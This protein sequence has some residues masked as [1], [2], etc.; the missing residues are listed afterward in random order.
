MRRIG[1]LFITSGLPEDVL[2]DPV[3]EIDRNGD[4]FVICCDGFECGIILTSEGDFD[5][6]TEDLSRL[7]AIFEKRSR[8]DEERGD[9]AGLGY[10]VYKFQIFKKGLDD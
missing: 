8:E 3:F 10:P 5:L 4:F 6:K 7:D 9:F 2:R 1:F